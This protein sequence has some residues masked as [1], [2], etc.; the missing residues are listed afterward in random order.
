MFNRIA[1][2]WGKILYLEKLD[3]GCLYSN[4]LCIL[5]TGNL[6][7]LEM[8]KIIHKGK[9]FLVRAK[10]TTRWIPDFDEQEE[11]N[12]E[13]KDEQSICF[14]KEDFAGSDAKKERDNNVSMVPGS[15]TEDANVQAEEK[16]NDLDVN[17]SLDP[18]ELYPLLNKKR[19][20]EEKMDKSN[21]T[22]SIPF[23][24]GFTPFDETEVEC[25]K[26]SMGNN[27]GSGF[28]NEKGESVS[29]G[30]N[31]VKGL[32]SKS[33]ENDHSCVACLKGKQH[34][35]SCKF[36]AKRDEG[37]FIR[38]SLCSKAFRVFNKR[39]K[40]I[41][42]NLHVDFLENK[43]IEK[44]TGPDWL[45][46]IDTLT[47]FMNYVPVIVAGI[48]ST[49]ILGTKEDVHQA[50][51]EKESPLR[52]I[53]LPN[54]NSNPTTSTKVFTNDS[55]EL[56]SSSIV[57][58]KVPTINTRVPTDSLSVPPITSS[59]LIIISREGSSFPEPLSLENVMSF[60][61][62]LEDF[63]GDTSNAVSLNKVEAN[64]SSMETA[65]Q[66]RPT[67]TL[68]IHKDHPKSQ[69]IGHV[70]THVQNRQKTKNVD[71]QSF[72]AIIHQKTNIDLLQY[73][74][75]STRFQ[76]P[77]RIRPVINIDF[78]CTI[79]ELKKNE[80]EGDIS[81]QEVKRAV[82]D[83]GIDKSLGPDGIT[84]G[85]IRR[86][87]SLIEK[88][89]VAAVQHFFT[90]GKFD[91][92]RDEGY[93]IRYSLCS[94]AF[95]VFNKRTKK[96]KENLHVDFLENKS[97]EKGTGPDWLFDIDT[98][99]NFM[100]YVPVIVAGI[101]STGILGTKED[102][103]QAVKEKESPL[104][105]IDLPNWNSNPTASTKVFTN[106]SFELA[107]SSIVETKVP[108]I[109]TPVPTDSLSVPPITSSVLIII[110]REGSS[111][112]EP[113]SL[114]N[115]MSFENR[116]EDFFGDT[117]NAVSLNKVE[118]NLSSMETA[119]QVR[120]TPTLK[121]HKDHP[122]SQIIGH[123]D[124]HVQNRQKTKNVDEQSFIA[125]I[126]QKTNIDLL[127]YC[128]FSCFLLQKEPKKIVDALKDPS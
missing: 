42:E 126:H 26:K 118:A 79:S 70:D 20:V 51:K 96:I 28:G 128:L 25:D 68:R 120:P 61:N 115:V 84:F 91:A 39:T 40:K 4:R 103:H 105:F 92:K 67:P 31:L 33:F 116:L 71:E 23:P 2:K 94:K 15:V 1:A 38:Y 53:D 66:V 69:I 63:F 100:N 80:L 107:S 11:D 76:Q 36:D 72:I 117:S 101:S 73:W 114:E 17:N 9:I 81:Y 110:S 121:I 60:E 89:V 95:R 123:V 30:S 106:D 55:F 124:T 97:I 45:F 104:R 59:V 49:G 58:T 29:I 43:S 48:S 5:T 37:Y 82:W 62:R 44:G 98:L 7:I 99:T 86:Y 125:I 102:V 8:F 32:P 119:I 22:V 83:C 52:F 50:V 24:L 108:T 111:F 88:D 56:A 13:S 75:F 85:F 127:Q 64:L 57:E 10:E 74:H 18:F 34:K 16:G 46:D 122:K 112:P 93:F 90:S 6:N 47:N 65:I 19:N 14:I 21:G 27:E 54:W 12:S 87:W 78:L 41:K 35:A 113:L 77:R 109:N 3:E